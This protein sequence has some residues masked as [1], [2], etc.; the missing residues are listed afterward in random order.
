MGEGGTELAEAVRLDGSLK[1]L[2][3]SSRPEQL[4][5]QFP[6]MHL[7]FEGC[8]SWPPS[9]QDQISWCLCESPS[10]NGRA[11]SR[12]SEERA[13]LSVIAQN[14]V[15][16]SESRE[17]PGG[18]VWLRFDGPQDTTVEASSLA[19]EVRLIFWFYWAPQLSPNLS[20][21]PLSGLVVSAFTFSRY[22]GSDE[23]LT[24]SYLWKHF[25]H[26]YF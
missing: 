2:E 26:F 14:S 5:L 17:S 9:L 4:I 10:S 21:L 11:Q 20:G 18:N 6:H 16:L 22:A 7:K 8:V 13:P 19:W 23:D 15:G 3:W 24:W 1:G 25:E 12:A